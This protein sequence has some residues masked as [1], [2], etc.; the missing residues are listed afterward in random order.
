MK[1][2]SPPPSKKNNVKQKKKENKKQNKKKN[3]TKKTIGIQLLGVAGNP[4]VYIVTLK[5][6]I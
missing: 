6:T 3:K 1:S 2:L 4:I 5:N